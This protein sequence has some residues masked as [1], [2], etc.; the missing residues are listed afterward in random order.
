MDRIKLPLQIHI[1]YPKTATTTLQKHLFS[2]DHIIHIDKSTDRSYSR[3]IIFQNEIPFKEALAHTRSLIMNDIASQTAQKPDAQAIVFSNES[4]IT[5]SLL[6]RYYPPPFC[7]TPDPAAIARK[8]SLLFNKDFC[9]YDPNIIISIRKQTELLKSC[10]AQY[11]N[12][13]YKKH[14]ETNSFEKF[15]SYAYQKNFDNFIGAALNFDQIVLYYEQLFHRNN[16]TIV[17]YEDLIEDLNRY[18]ALWACILNL[19]EDTVRFSLNNQENVKRLKKDFYRQDTRPFLE[20]IG[21]NTY[22][23]LQNAS[24]LLPAAISSPIKKW[25]QTFNIPGRQFKIHFENEKEIMDRYV[26]G[27]SKLAERFSLDLGKYGY[28]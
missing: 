19:P 28:C 15:I 14:K 21:R 23:A 25:F 12:L 11:Y 8:L 4:F 22:T 7:W 5:N 6:F 17:V 3:A 10:Y 18:A 13:V 1:G 26:D 20:G 16:I 27:N 9:E 2:N 24:Y